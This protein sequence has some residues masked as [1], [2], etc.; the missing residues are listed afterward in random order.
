M[1][2]KPKTTE[3]KAKDKLTEL[4]AEYGQ[5]CAERER[6]QVMAENCRRRAAQVHQQI[7][8]VKK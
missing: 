6:H 4:W 2:K 7:M 5:L 1:S 3:N 8:S